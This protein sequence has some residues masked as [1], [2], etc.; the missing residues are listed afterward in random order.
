MLSTNL[1]KSNPFFAVIYMGYPHFALS[2]TELYDRDVTRTESNMI[3]FSCEKVKALAI[4]VKR[5]KTTFKDLK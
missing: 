2:V 1:V 3:D 4:F 5:S